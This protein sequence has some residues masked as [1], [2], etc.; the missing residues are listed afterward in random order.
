MNGHKLYHTREILESFFRLG[1]ACCAITKL[2]ISAGEEASECPLE[3]NTGV[4]DRA[5]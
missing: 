1:F 4:R 3:T 2:E 5:V